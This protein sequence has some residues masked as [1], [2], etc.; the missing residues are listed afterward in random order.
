MKSN[1]LLLIMLTTAFVSCGQPGK[2][3][4][5]TVIVETV[6]S[7]RRYTYADAMGKQVIF[8]NSLPRGTTYNAPDGKHYF[9]WIFWSGITNETDKPLEIDMNFPA[10]FYEVPGATGNRYKILVPPDTMSVDKEQ[11]Y[12]YGMTGLTAFLDTAINK[13]STL[14][15]TILPNQSTGFYIVLLSL[16]TDVATGFTMRTGLRVKGQNLVYTISRYA[17]K[18][19]HPLLSQEEIS[20]GSISL[21]DLV[22]Q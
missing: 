2:P 9:R 4:S 18:K 8:T 3:N 12:N 15:R 17:D 16:S 10:A 22:L 20:C 14:M 5:D 13:P 1:L 11:L 7:V 21:K 6:N 19:D